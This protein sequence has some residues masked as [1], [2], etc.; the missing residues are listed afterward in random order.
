MSNFVPSKDHFREALLFCFNLKKSAAASHRWLVEAYGE[1][2]PSESTCRDWFRR[3]KDG[4]FEVK[5]KHRSGQ[6]RKFSDEDV[7]KLLDENPSR[8]LTELAEL[9]NVSM[10]T[11]SKR[12]KTMDI[13]QK[14]G[15][16][17]PDDQQP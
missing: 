15:S 11:V 2:V 3:F 8:T 6:P 5:D 9:L 12:L 1:E 14:D 13:V 16:W 4:D 10:A 17:V 7:K